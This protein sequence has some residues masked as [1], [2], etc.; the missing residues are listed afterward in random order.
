MYLILS[1]TWLKWHFYRSHK[2]AIFLRLSISIRFCKLYPISCHVCMPSISGLWY[3]LDA[4]EEIK[5]KEWIDQAKK[6]F[7]D[8]ERNRLEQLEKTKANNRYNFECYIQISVILLPGYVAFFW[9]LHNPQFFAC[10]KMSWSPPVLFVLIVWSSPLSKHWRFSS[11][12]YLL[13]KLHLAMLL[14]SYCPLLPF[15]FMLIVLCHLDFLW[16]FVLLFIFQWNCSE[17]LYKGNDIR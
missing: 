16:I 12:V 10:A 11:V 3:L 5:R 4:E 13:G 2:S 17:W 8:W 6:E 14:A 9:S 15:V 7:D 1:C